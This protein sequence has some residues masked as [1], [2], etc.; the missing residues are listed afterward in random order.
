MATRPDPEY[1]VSIV[2]SSDHAGLKPV[3]KQLEGELYH[4]L[5]RIDDPRDVRD[6]LRRLIH[7]S[8][9]WMDARAKD[10]AHK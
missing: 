5:A 2:V 3:F 8:E 1:T 6:Y 9:L 4:A 10:F 7:A